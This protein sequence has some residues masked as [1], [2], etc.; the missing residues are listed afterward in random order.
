M[1]AASD[2]RFWSTVG[3]VIK[4]SCETIKEL[5]NFCACF[6]AIAN[7][8]SNVSQK[9][10]QAFW[11][12]AT[13]EK[14][15]K[16][17]DQTYAHHSSLFLILQT[18]NICLCSPA[19][20]V[21][22]NDLNR[23]IDLLVQLITQTSSA[24]RSDIEGDDQN[25]L[26]SHANTELIDAVNNVAKAA[27]LIQSQ[28]HTSHPPS[29]TFDHVE[30]WRQQL[31]AAANEASSQASTTSTAHPSQ[32]TPPSS[33]ETSSETTETP[34]HDESDSEDELELEVLEQCLQE[35][36]AAL[37]KSRH[38]DAALFYREAFSIA[39]SLSPKKQERFGLSD[40]RLRT[41]VCCFFENNFKEAEKIATEVKNRETISPTNA[42]RIRKLDATQLLA[43][44]YLCSGKYREA[45]KEC[46]AAWKGRYKALGKQDLSCFVSLSLLSLIMEMQGNYARAITYK[47]MIPSNIND[48]TVRARRDRVIESAAGGPAIMHSKNIA[49]V[50]NITPEA[51]AKGIDE[52]FNKFVR[53]SD[54]SS[55]GRLLYDACG[56][57]LANLVHLLLTGWSPRFELYMPGHQG[58]STVTT[59]D[60]AAVYGPFQETVLHAAIQGGNV[61]VFKLLLEAGADLKTTEG[62]EIFRGLIKSK[63][64]ALIDHIMGS[65]DSQLIDY[66]I[67]KLGPDFTALKDPR[68]RNLA[69]I[70]RDTTGGWE[71]LNERI[72]NWYSSRN[73]TRPAWQ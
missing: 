52:F 5:H 61:A 11:L 3:D 10:L 65:K 56:Q 42:D 12:D 14:L 43:E 54:D 9:P 8:D 39:E 69:A 33:L 50:K 24:H 72:D 32:R 71:W 35:A 64:S 68:G 15:K 62:R 48:A 28:S 58:K 37:K 21:I 73:R 41:A 6:K 55:V 51:R 67:G 18:M 59:K 27:K 49:K 34:A 29:Q 25:S 38:E 31:R 26:H 2:M 13:A 20:D 19:P 70:A 47:N 7:K 23:K 60:I 16:L 17:R 63:D 4:N 40:V 36:N 1:F 44:I 30:S 66:M 45:E 22:I 57:G 46:R 53:N